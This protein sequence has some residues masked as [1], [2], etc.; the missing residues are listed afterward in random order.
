MQL[1]MTF[2][3][4]K[5][6][7]VKIILSLFQREEGRGEINALLCKVRRSQKNDAILL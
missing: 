6:K 4:S 3:H 1:L 5:D 2:K 7:G